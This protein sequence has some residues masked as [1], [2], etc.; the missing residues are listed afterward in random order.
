MDTS[1]VM[2]KEPKTRHGPLLDKE[3]LALQRR[4]H[5]AHKQYGRGRKVAVGS[6][7]DK[8]L[9]TKL[10]ALEDKYKGATL[11]AK[12]A[13]ILLEQQDGFLEAEDELEK[14]YRVRQD[15][16]KQSVGIET[17]KKGFDLKLSEALGPYY[18]NYG[19]NGRTLL[20][21]GR[22]GF[23]SAIGDWRAGKLGLF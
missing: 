2:G 23:V 8:A 15:E 17:A 18:L 11:A 16:I 20:L 7:K 6:V 9:R 19:R 1:A 21:A 4:K 14:T 13:E 10:R 3:A 5:E 22:N 12:N